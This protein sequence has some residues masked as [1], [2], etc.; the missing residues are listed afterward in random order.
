[1][2]TANPKTAQTT[3]GGNISTTSKAP[4]VRR[5]R[6][7]R[8]IL[9]DAKAQGFDIYDDREV[10]HRCIG[11]MEPMPWAWGCAAGADLAVE[12][13]QVAR[14]N[15][16]LGYNQ[17]EIIDYGLKDAF[18]HLGGP[19]LDGRCRASIAVGMLSTMCE[20]L[21]Q[22]LICGY[23]LPIAETCLDEAVHVAEEGDREET[24]KLKA[25]AID[26][27]KAKAQEV[28]A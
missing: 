12:V 7:K 1:M 25:R 19:R 23:A 21:T 8:Q 16:E 20:V 5:V 15:G 4:E 24:K 27:S 14:L 18:K 9:A 28:A 13:L 22:T 6:T 2:K 17:S 11:D 3:T 26:R 10:L